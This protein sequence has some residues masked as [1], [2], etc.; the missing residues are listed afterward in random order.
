[1]DKEGN[2]VGRSP[3]LITDLNFAL[4]RHFSELYGHRFSN[5]LHFSPNERIDLR[6]LRGKDLVLL[7]LLIDYEDIE[8]ILKGLMG[9][10]SLSIY[11]NVPFNSDVL[12]DY[13][14]TWY[15]DGNITCHINTKLGFKYYES[16]IMS[17]VEIL[18]KYNP[19]FLLTRELL[20]YSRF[21]MRRRNVMSYDGISVSRQQYAGGYIT[22]V[23]LYLEN[24]VHPDLVGSSVD[25]VWYGCSNGFDLELIS[26]RGEYVR[27]EEKFPH[28]L[29]KFN[30]KEYKILHYVRRKD[31]SL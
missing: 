23:S 11:T 29:M 6:T 31:R 14:E 30:D 25:Y 26:K 10:G 27:G 9:V 12:G 4:H 28:Y 8:K 13:I 21:F 7:N 2:L 1:M 22:D 17:S 3:V 24:G 5:V 20:G 15:L 16:C 18:G 19:D